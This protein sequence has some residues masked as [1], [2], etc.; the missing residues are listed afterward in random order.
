MNSAKIA[1]SVPAPL[2]ERLEAVRRRSGRS[3]SALVAEALQAWLDQAEPDDDDRRYVEGYLK[4]PERTEETAG[5]AAAAIAS[6][7]PWDEAR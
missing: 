4:H 7:E 1:V 5:V 2:L 6:W 3:R